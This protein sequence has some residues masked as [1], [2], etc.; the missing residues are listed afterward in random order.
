MSL[1]ENLKTNLGMLKD[2]WQSGREE[3]SPEKRA[4]IIRQ[5]RAEALRRSKK[6]EALVAKMRKDGIS[7]NIISETEANYTGNEY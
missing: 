3:K 7:E 1:L 6:L 4:A 5:L 2:A